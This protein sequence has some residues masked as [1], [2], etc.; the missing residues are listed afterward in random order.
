MTQYFQQDDVRSCLCANLRRASRA[1]TQLY[2]DALRPTGLTVEQ[3]NLLATLS[4]SLEIALSDLARRVGTD[5]T[6]LTRNLGPLIRKGLVADGAARDQRVRMIRLTERG[7]EVYAAAEE[8]WRK[9]QADVTS[10]LG[11]DR[12]GELLD[13]LNAIT[14]DE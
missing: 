7:R 2:N 8:R 11:G 13:L 10:R 6:T 4:F 5:R 14:S 12:A 9:I 3:F 1:V